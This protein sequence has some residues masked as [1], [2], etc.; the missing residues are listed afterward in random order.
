[1][2]DW[3]DLEEVRMEVNGCN[4]NFHLDY[5]AQDHYSSLEV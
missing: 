1:M 4:V 3:L 2:K 5:D